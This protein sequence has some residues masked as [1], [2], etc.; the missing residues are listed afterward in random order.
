MRNLSLRRAGRARRYHRPLRIVLRSPVVYWAAAALLGLLTFGVLQAR[1]DELARRSVALGPTRRVAV[2]T[3]DLDAGE[4][5]T[6]ADI[7][8]RALPEAMVPETALTAAPVD[9]RLRVDVSAGEVLLRT[10]LTDGPASAL[11][12]AVPDDWRALAVPLPPG[13]LELSP[14]D[15][16]D[17]LAL[18]GEGVSTA[19][20]TDALVIDANEASAT[21]AVP[22]RAVGEV[23]DA[24]LAATV[25]LVLSGPS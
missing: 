15:R 13:G 11:A 7:E 8:L 14:G 17:V 20:A 12:A 25:T 22:R 21:I 3:S 18:A 5:L 16:V 9:A 4:A 10:R 6:A 1:S 23:A 19:V 24:V 2:V